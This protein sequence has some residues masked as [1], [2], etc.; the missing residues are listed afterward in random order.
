MLYMIGLG[1]SDGKDIT[2]RGL[3]AL[4]GSSRV[5]LEGYTSLLQCSLEEL[6]EQLEVD[7]TI[8]SREDVEQKIEPI[9]DEAA[10]DDVSLLIIG[11]PFAATTHADLFLRAKARGLDITVIHN[12]SILT[13][14]GE[15]GL[16]LYKYGRTVSIPY[17][18]KSYEPTSFLLGIIENL[19][20]GMHTLCLLD[21][22]SAQERF[23]T[24]PEALSQLK[25]A[26][27]EEGRA[28]DIKTVIGV[29]RLGSE[30]QKILV[31]S[32]DDVRK[33]DFGGPPHC[34]LIPGTLS[35]IEEEMLSLRE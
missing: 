14:I 35:A 9:L 31:G 1:L 12:A 30:D 29:A 27:G 5:Y 28:L 8:L 21:I 17:W 16:E 23:M 4:H 13:A 25:K 10:N 33:H 15:I 32:P 3:E 18:E 34:L 26:A 2:L 6:E 20:R 7:L 22:K 11:D 19:E 24:I